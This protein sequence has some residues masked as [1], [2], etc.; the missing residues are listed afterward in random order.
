MCVEAAY[1]KEQ[2]HDTPCKQCLSTPLRI[3]DN[4]GKRR[5]A[6]G[7]SRKADST[8]ASTFLFPA[9]FYA[10]L[11]G[12]Y[13]DY[14]YQNVCNRRQVDSRCTFYFGHKCRIGAA[15][16]FLQTAFPRERKREEIR[17]SLGNIVSK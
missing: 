14:I 6:T 3:H 2:H 17:D 8:V 15:V 4:Q 10:A 7:L 16:K 12:P 11:R 5:D 13:V 9:S 1:P